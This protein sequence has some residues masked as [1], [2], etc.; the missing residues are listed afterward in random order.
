ML[1]LAA[2]DSR[3]GPLDDERREV[4]AVY[5]GEH[6]V[7]VREPAVRNPHLLAVEHEAPVLLANRAGFG[8]ERV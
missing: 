3:E 4:L 6:D 1:F 7:E 2:A 5:L 8:A